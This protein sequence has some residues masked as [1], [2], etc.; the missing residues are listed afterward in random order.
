MDHLC[1]NQDIYVGLVSQ[2]GLLSLLEPLDP[3]SISSWREIDALYP[4]GQMQRSVEPCLSLSFQ[5]SV[6]LAVGGS[7]IDVDTTSILF[8]ISCRQHIKI[9]GSTKAEDEGLVLQEVC[10]FPFSHSVIRSIAWANGTALLGNLIAVL[11]DDGVIKLLDI[12]YEKGVNAVRDQSNGSSLVRS[13]QPTTQPISSSGISAGLAGLARHNS[14]ETPESQTDEAALQAS[15]REVGELFEGNGDQMTG[16]T[17]V[18]A[19][20]FLATCHSYSVTANCKAGAMLVSM[21]RN[22]V[23]YMWRQ[24]VNGEW[25]KYAES[26]FA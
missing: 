5:R 25:M 18:Q 19:G 1:R 15:A 20:E 11:F 16:M 4:F 23:A 3:D 8:A 10:N 14:T 21:G 13:G 24:G 22:G 2:T 7:E 26:S 17:W 12:K 9:Y 6:S